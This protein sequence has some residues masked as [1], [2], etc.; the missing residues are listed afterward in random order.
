MNIYKQCRVNIKQLRRDLPGWTWRAVQQ[1][2]GSWLYIGH[3]DERQVEVYARAHIGSFEDDCSI[4][5]YASERGRCEPFASW[6][7]RQPAE[8]RR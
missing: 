1:G 3:Q 4:E 6:W 5:W 8:R 2:F 7:M